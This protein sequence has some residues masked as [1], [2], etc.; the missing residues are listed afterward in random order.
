[1]RFVADKAGLGQI[2]LRIL[3]FSPPSINPPMLHTHLH[4]HVALTRKTNGRSLRTFHDSL[5]FRI[6]GV[7]I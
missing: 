4:L 6:S 1:M 7:V 5:F 2:F 3:P